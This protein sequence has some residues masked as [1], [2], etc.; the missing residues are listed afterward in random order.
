MDI[1]NTLRL[2]SNPKIEIDFSGGTLSSD[3]GLFLM[4]EFL[5]QIGFLDILKK[6]FATTDTASYRIH[7]DVENLLQAL[8]QIFAGYFEDNRADKL[9]NEPVITVCVGKDSLASQPTM[10][11]FF[12][13]LDEKTLDQFNKILRQLRKLIYKITGA[14]NYVM[15]DIDTT[16]LNTYGNQEGA[17]WNFHYQD[18][19]YHPQLCFDCVTGDLIKMQLRKGTQYCS[20]GIA[21]FMKPIFEEY[22]K[23]YPY[24]HLMLRGDSG[25]AAPELYE[26]C[27]HYGVYYIIRLKVNARLYTLAADLDEKLAEQTKENMIAPSE[28]YGEFMYQADSWSKPRRVV[29][30]IEKPRDSME[31]RFTF[32]VTNSDGPAELVI[33]IYCGRGAMENLIKECKNDFDFAAVSSKSMV[34]N[35]NRLQIHG[36]AYTLFNYMRRLVLPAHLIKARMETIRLNLIK[37]ASRVV[38]HGRRLQFRLCSSYPYQ[39]EFVEIMNNIHSLH[40]KAI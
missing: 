33:N 20:T 39:E 9:I 24:T 18:D 36:L 22:T 25:Y 26:L 29:C 31:H 6:Y 3:S 13:R 12:N 28:V 4:K 37:I 40:P 7:T 23:N 17:A 19:G 32:V 15:F 5:Y 14:P 21:E 35:S 2:N 10:S 16:L 38:K 34:V 1:V 8:Y 27:E 11:R 30:K